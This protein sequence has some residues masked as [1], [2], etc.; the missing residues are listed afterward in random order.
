[1]RQT[2]SQSGNGGRRGGGSSV[3]LLFV[4]AALLI[5]AAFG[6]TRTFL[7]QEDGV[8]AFVPGNAVAY[9]H[10]GGRTAANALLSS[11]VQ[12]PSGIAPDEVSVFATP[13][14]D[15]LRWGVLVGWRPPRT[16]SEGER[17]ALASRGAVAL[18]ARRYLIG[19][20]S[21]SVA[22][23][24][25]AAA[26][27][28]LADDRK[29]SRALALMRSVASVQA[30]A[31]PSALL[32]S[33]TV[34][35]LAG[36]SADAVSPSVAAINLASGSIRARVLTLDAAAAAYGILGYREKT[37]R[38][39]H[40]DLRRFPAQIA[41]TEDRPSFDV[42]KLLGGLVRPE[43]HPAP[44]VLNAAG[45]ELRASLA[46][47]YALWLRPDAEKGRVG[48]LLRF[49]GKDAMS[50]KKDV[51]RYAAAI[52]PDRRVL[53]LPDGAAVTEFRIDTDSREAEM[54]LQ[55]ATVAIGANPEVSVVVGDDG[56]HGAIVASSAELVAEFRGQKASV[57]D[58]EDGCPAADRGSRLEIEA[59]SMLLKPIPQAEAAINALGLKKIIIGSSMGGD[60]EI[61]ICGYK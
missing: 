61:L 59:P 25:A 57:A 31:E 42:A 48:F 28:S 37:P 14:D 13:G 45:D 50:V 20:D 3:T 11:S 2:H 52:N 5:A 32:P 58:D 27:A 54:G 55:D 30:Y 7:T 46:L 60:K 53:R 47:P 23:R 49:P 15:A 22:S 40:T 16:P 26:H 29:K 9:L 56:E 24:V 18:D 44:A 21:L 36:V 10:A 6:L 41:V 43:D 34:S 4:A 1:M 12:M 19:D 51:A 33:E 38:T 35:M 39:A 8:A 17:S